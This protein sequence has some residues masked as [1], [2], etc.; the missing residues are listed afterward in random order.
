MIAPIST[1]IRGTLG[2]IPLGPEEGL[3]RYCVADT[4]SIDL[5]EK[6]ALLHKLGVLNS[7]KREQLDAALRFTLGLD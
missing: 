5:I 4:A 6:S 2:E 3:P 1:R 7:V